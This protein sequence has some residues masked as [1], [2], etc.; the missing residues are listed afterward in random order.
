MS[1]N[2][3]VARLPIRQPSLAGMFYPEKPA[4]LTA[5]LSAYFRNTVTSETNPFGILVPHAGYIYSAQT[6][7]CSYAKIPSDFSGTFVILGPS[8]QGLATSTSEVI[9]QTPIGNVEPDTDFIAALELPKRDDYIC[10]QENSI[11]VQIPFIAHRFPKAKIVPVLFGDQSPAGAKRA[12]DAIIKAIQSTGIIPKIIASSDG[13]H[14]V[15]KARA[16]ADDLTVLNALKN[17]DTALFYRF[18]QKY[19]PSMCGFGCIAAMSEVCKYLG[20]KEA[21]LLLYS[22]SGDITGDFEEVVGYASM[23]VV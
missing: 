9:W 15:P 1:Q 20:A 11:E 18:L 17:L 3:S 12:A 21:R 23:E 13:S 14:Y 22:T 16:M 10:A 7:A 2:I 19:R 8:H 5:Q 4:D 6:A